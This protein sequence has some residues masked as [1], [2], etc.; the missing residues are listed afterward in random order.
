[1]LAH[2]IEVFGIAAKQGKEEARDGI[3]EKVGECIK[4]HNIYGEEMED[5]NQQL[6][7]ALEQSGPHSYEV[8]TECE[9]GMKKD[10]GLICLLGFALDI[11]IFYASCVM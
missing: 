10:F 6:L 4:H 11:S 5:L 2:L 8:G 7:E 1:M 9:R 3:L